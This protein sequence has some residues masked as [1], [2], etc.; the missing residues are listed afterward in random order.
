MVEWRQGGNA[1]NNSINNILL[2]AMSRKGHNSDD[3]RKER[4]WDER[5]RKMLPFLLS[6]EAAVL[7]LNTDSYK[8]TFLPTVRY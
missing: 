2:L 8:E 4:K 7:Q 6:V 1:I 3:L 5:R